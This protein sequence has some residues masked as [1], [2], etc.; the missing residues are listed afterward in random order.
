[1]AKSKLR[2]VAPSTENRTVATPRRK[3][4]AELRSRE[5]LTEGEMA[6]LMEAAKANRWGH[7][8]ATMVLVAYRH[9]L[10]ASEL[11]PFPFRLNRNVT[12][13]LAG[14]ACVTGVTGANGANRNG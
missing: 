2:I 7:R 14:A 3:P 11:E 12:L 1:M 8:D 6:K 9:G 4:N 10:R 5:Y 13:F